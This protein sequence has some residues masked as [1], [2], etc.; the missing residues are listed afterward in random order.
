MS[1]NIAFHYY[2]LVCLIL[3]IGGLIKL[4]V[5]FFYL[6]IFYC[7]NSCF[8]IFTLTGYKINGSSKTTF[9]SHSENAEYCQMSEK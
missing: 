5:F 1:I 4:L 6:L 8:K 9:L 3:Y 7:C 2:A